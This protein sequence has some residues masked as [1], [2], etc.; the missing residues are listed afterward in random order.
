MCTFDEPDV[1]CAKLQLRKKQCWANKRKK[2]KQY[3][4]IVF[5]KS[6]NETR[7]TNAQT[8]KQTS[9]PT[10]NQVSQQS[11]RLI[12]AASWRCAPAQQTNWGT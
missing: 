1:G 10:R 9:K 7:D 4:T 2:K 6:M 8:T 12:V 11:M 5:D 3:S